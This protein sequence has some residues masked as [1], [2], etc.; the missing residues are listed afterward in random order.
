MPSLSVPSLAPGQ[1][2]GE[3]IELLISTTPLL[4]EEKQ[5]IVIPP[6]YVNCE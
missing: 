3:W 2:V 5:R 6:V 4:K 1:K